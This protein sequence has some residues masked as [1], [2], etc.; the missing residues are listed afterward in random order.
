MEINDNI[1]KNHEV[2]KLFKAMLKKAID[3]Y[4]CIEPLDV[5]FRRGVEWYVFE[6]GLHIAQEMIQEIQMLRIENEMLKKS[7]QRQVKE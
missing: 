5:G 7:L 6:S 4:S 1:T 2:V 3:D